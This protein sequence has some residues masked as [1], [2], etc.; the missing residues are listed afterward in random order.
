MS[1]VKDEP[2]LTAETLKAE[3]GEVYK[4]V[5]EAGRAEGSQAERNRFAA[6]QGVCGEDRELL[7][8]A[9]AEGRDEPW[10]LKEA[11][12]RLATQLKAAREQLAKPSAGKKLQHDAATQ[13]FLEQPAP[14]KSGEKNGPATFMEAVKAHQAEFKISEAEAVRECVTRYPEL[15]AKLQSGE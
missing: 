14:Q 4:A 15:H 6:L 13:E 1:H 2:G 10:A 9:F 3:H 7:V 12:G 5:F 8:T 11:N